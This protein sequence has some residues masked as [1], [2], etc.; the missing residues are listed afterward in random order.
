MCQCSWRDKIRQIAT[1]GESGDGDRKR[2]LRTG[3]AWR[4]SLTFTIKFADYLHSFTYRFGEDIFERQGFNLSDPRLRQS[5]V[6]GRGW[7]ADL[8]AQLYRR[9]TERV[10]P[11]PCGGYRRTRSSEWLGR[12]NAVVTHVGDVGE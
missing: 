3:A 11:V 12:G 5:G 7:S 4:T 1:S 10:R 8:A 9:M 6:V 2:F